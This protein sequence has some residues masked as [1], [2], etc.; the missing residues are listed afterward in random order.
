MPV[1]N[2]DLE[3]GLPPVSF[4]LKTE[5]CERFMEFMAECQAIKEEPQRKPLKDEQI[6]SI[7]DKFTVH[8]GDM[9][10]PELCI[11]FNDSCKSVH[12][13]ARAIEAAHGIKGDA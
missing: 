6:D 13:F 11:E 3:D 8:T 7:A 4:S 10:E 1:M 12:S 2:F 9:W 5:D